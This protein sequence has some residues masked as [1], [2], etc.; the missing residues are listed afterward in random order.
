MVVSRRGLV[1][2][3]HRHVPPY[4]IDNIPFGAEVSELLAWLR[5]L[6]TQIMAAGGDWRS[7]VDA[8]RPHTQRLWRLMTL[9]QKRRF[10]RHARAFWDIHRHR[11][12]PEIEAR[13]AALRATGRLTVVAGRVLSAVKRGD[14][15]C[16]RVL[17]RNERTPEELRFGRVIDCAGLP[18]DPAQSNNP[19]IR[20]LL[21]SGSARVDPLG[22]GLDVTHRCAL[23]DAGGNASRRVHAIGPLARAALWE[24]IAIP[25]IR[26]QCQELA[27]SL[28]V[29]QDETETTGGRAARA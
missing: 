19:L 5:G 11:M 9:E 28:A 21:A 12:A 3:A 17:R 15:I 6:S 8:V 14:L 29:E 10:L 24:C 20:S 1:P 7:A 23:I 13:I 18:G 16:A 25:D 26:A 2:L 27:Q 4:R 22:I